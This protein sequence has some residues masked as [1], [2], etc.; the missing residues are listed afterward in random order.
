[1]SSVA[2]Q[3]S[4]LRQEERS[5]SLSKSTS[6][7]NRLESRRVMASSSKEAPRVTAVQLNDRTLARIIQGVTEKV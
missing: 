7:V 1:M 3:A 4:K 2:S 6:T 5:N